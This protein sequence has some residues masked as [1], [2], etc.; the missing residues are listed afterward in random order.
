MRNIAKNIIPISDLQRQA[1]Q[2]VDKLSDD[3]IIITQHG[4]AAAVLISPQR[5][6]EMEEEL[7]RLD[8]VELVTMLQKAE[9]DIAAGKTIS[10]EEVKKRLNYSKKKK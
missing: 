7:R 10:H 5:Y 4:R 2:I 6:D 9:A 3:P 1:G 8:D